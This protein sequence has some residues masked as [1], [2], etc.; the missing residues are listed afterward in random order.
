VRRSSDGQLDAVQWGAKGDRLVSADY[1]GDRKEDFAVYRKDVGTWWIRL[2]STGQWYS[3][4]FGDSNSEPAPADYDGD[5]K[6][7]LAVSR[8]G[9]YRFLMSTGAGEET[10]DRLLDVSPESNHNDINVPGDYDGDARADPAVLHDPNPET[11]EGEEPHQLEP[12]IWIIHFSRTGQTGTFTFGEVGDEP[13]PGDYNGDGKTDIAVWRPNTHTWH[14]VEDLSAGASLAAREVQWGLEE[15]KVAPGDYDGDGRFDLAVWRPSEG[16]WYILNSSTGAP[17][18]PH[19]G[20]PG[21]IPV[22]MSLK[23]HEH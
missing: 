16:T 1:D 13:V 20:Q 22:P 8:R 19:W 4:Q 23:R 15:D 10:S 3:R 5:G 17:D 14:I 7:D 2:S 6:A 11:P 18:Y 21:D 9:E 12:R